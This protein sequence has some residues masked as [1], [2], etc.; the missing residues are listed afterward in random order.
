MVVPA[1]SSTDSLPTRALRTMSS[2]VAQNCA[3]SMASAALMLGT[4]SVRDPS[5]LGTSMAR[6]KFTCAG[7]TKAGLP[8]S[9][10]VN[11]SFIWGID[12]SALTMA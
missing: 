5:G 3:K 4:R 10:T 8:C 2:Y 6:P 12:L 1:K 9:V 11:E 7:V